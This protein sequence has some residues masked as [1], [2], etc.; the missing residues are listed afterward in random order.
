V[1]V[2]STE[3][4]RGWLRRLGDVVGPH[5]VWLILGLG[6]G[7]GAQL[8]LA[9]TPLIHRHVIDNVIVARAGG[10]EPW[11]ILLVGAGFGRFA[12][13]VAQRYA[14]GRV[15]L[16]V[17]YDL[18]TAI[19]SHLQ[20]LD[21]AR[22][23]ELHT[24]QV[25]SRAITDLNAVQQM[26]GFLPQLL[27][28]FVFFVSALMIMLLLSPLLAAVALVATPLMFLVA[29]KL[30]DVIYPATWDSS[31][32][33][34]VVAG[35]VEEVVSGVRIVKGF[36]QEQRELAR[37]GRAAQSLYAARVRALR[38][39]ARYGATLQSLPAL[40]QVGILAIG[41]WLAIEGQLTLGTFLVCVG[42]V[43]QLQ[44]PTRLLANMFIIAQQGRASAER[45]FELLDSTPTVRE[46]KDATA[47]DVRG[48]EVE[49]DG[50]R[51][52]YLRSEPVVRDLT[53]TVRSGEAVALVGTAG[54][55]K[56]TVA[57]LLPRFYDVQ[58]G[59]I[60]IDGRDIREVTLHSLRER[61]G[62]VFED[63][64]L[65]SDTVRA[66]IAYGR[67]DATLEQIIAAAQS[68]EAH[69][70]IAALPHGYDTVVGEQGLTLSGGQRQR[71]A[72]ARALI[73]DPAILVLDDATSAVDTRIE[74]EIQATLRRLMKG[75]TTILI[76]RRRSTLHLADRICLMDGGSVAD[77]GT[78]DELMA[79]SRLYRQMLSG[80]GSEEGEADL[81]PEDIVRDTRVDGVTPE[82][83]ERDDEIGIEEAMR[84]AGRLQ[85]PAG[86]GGGGGGGV[87]MGG[88]GGHGFGGPALSMAMAL[89]PTPELY[90]KIAALPPPNDRPDMAV[91]RAA[92]DE[93]RFRFLRFVRPWG[94][95]LA[96]GALLVAI[97]SVVQISG[98]AIIRTGIDGGVVGGAMNVVLAAAA[99]FL[100]VALVGWIDHMAQ[101][102]IT[103]R[104]AERVLYALRIRIFAHLQRLS[105]SYYDQEL[106]GRIMTRMTSDVEAL[107][108]VM[109]QG[110]V[111]AL[112]SLVT[113]AGVAVTMLL[114]EPRLGLATMAVAVPLAI[115]AGFFRHYSRRAYDDARE[116]ISLVNADLQERVSGVR[117]TQAFVREGHNDR[118]FAGLA[119]GYF[120]ARMRAQTAIAALW[121]YIQLL[122]DVAAAIVLGVGAVLIADGSLTTGVLI[123]FL[124]YLSIFFT[125]IQQ[126]SMVFD[127]YQQAAVALSRIGE[128]LATPTGVPDANDAIRIPDGLRGR[129]ELRGVRFAYA[130]TLEEALRGVDLTIEPHETVAF[131]G[132]TGA[133]KSTIL[134]LVARYYD[135]TGGS[136]LIDGHDIRAL[137]L[138]E[139]R[140]HL[141][142]VPQEP[143]LF[144]GT[145]RDNIAYGRPDATEAEVEAAARAVGA[146]DVVATLPGGY[147]HVIGERGRT[148]SIGQ[149]QLLALARALIVDPDILLLDEATSN[150]DLAT[151]ARVTAAMGV[152]A[153]GR[154]TLLIAHR[155]PTAARADRIVVMD[156]GTV[157][158]IGTHTS[159]LSRG[160]IYARLWSAFADG[161]S[162]PP[163][164]RP[165]A[166][167]VAS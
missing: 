95:Q 58:E 147:R 18:R 135:V 55:G 69:E 17:Q 13:V 66:N 156:H 118:R 44:T 129:I 24:G 97:D 52:G 124:L 84:T 72:L 30:R 5:K 100:F 29:V 71:V 102:F 143:Y 137:D 162:A 117:V 47:L 59:A 1:R 11:L 155:L 126:L 20:R 46:R 9:L 19:F 48:G 56:S 62:I 79:R 16:Q 150:L 120:D 61:I 73:T 142:V 8:T 99:T 106:G 70:F 57:M 23:D 35:V 103:G 152:A 98:P 101:T 145:V 89:E 138:T 49:F 22:H 2:G 12:L 110:L 112:T 14:G 27:S 154:T 81:D 87:G 45:I 64:F 108:N 26:L 93:V 68:A 31:Q 131:V 21:F 134:K 40:A 7:I 113:C 141:G 148:L 63:S 83:W 32:K 90:A 86:G 140:H 107:T 96:V 121:G 159:L 42:Y 105:L 39:R 123:A 6:G 163:Q 28:Q 104:T 119:H 92:Q 139:Y 85:R 153:R 34:G 91:D 144:A 111:T 167:S 75:R 38:L 158:E 25:V 166:A 165:A 65:F 41:G 160:G 164:V 53:L 109:Q 125:P 15:S 50:V 161:Q 80:P 149:R 54:S 33:A 116:R 132:E 130:R 157:A 151:E 133:G 146:H 78:H 114:L 82:L 88:G 76:A 3:G 60:R 127:S 77:A 67:P 94:W 36:G 136:V 4:E 51:F 43:T 115:G 74:M 37:L 122:S 128:L 10:I